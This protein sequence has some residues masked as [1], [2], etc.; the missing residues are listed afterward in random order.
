MRGIP[1]SVQRVLE[2]I[3]ANSH[4]MDVLRTACSALGLGAARSRR[5]Q[6]RALHAISPTG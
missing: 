4:P 3:P 1:A 5:A 2:R 6:A